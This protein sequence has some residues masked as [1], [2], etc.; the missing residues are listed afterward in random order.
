MSRCIDFIDQPSCTKRVANQSS[1]SGWL[2]FSPRRPKSLAVATRPRPKWYCQMR[3]TITRV[4]RAFVGWAIQFVGHHYEG[5]KPAFVDD[6]VG[7]MIGPMFVVAEVM[8]HL[9]WNRPL[10]EAIE[11][12]VG[13]TVLRDLNVVRG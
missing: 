8:F 11:R 1:S 2:G 6:I 7:L 10:L 9:G 13:P 5:R 3:L 4:V 12:K